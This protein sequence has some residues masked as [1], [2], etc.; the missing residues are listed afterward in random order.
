VVPNTDLGGASGELGGEARSRHD[1][2]QRRQITALFC[3]LVGS[4]PLSGRLDP[5]DFRE[6]LALYQ[7]VVADAIDRYNGQVTQLLGDGVVACFGYPRAHEDDAQRAVYAGLE[8]LNDLDDLNARLKSRFDATLQVR[9][10]CHTGLVVAGAMEAGSKRDEFAM[11]GETPNV[12]ARLQAVATPGSLVV[13]EVTHGLIQ[14]EFETELLGEQTLVGVERPIVV[15]RVLRS[16]AVEDRLDSVGE[17]RRSPLIDREVEMDMLLAIWRGVQQGR[18]TLVQ[19]TGEPGIGKSRLIHALAERLGDE[20]G[21]AQRWQC[22]RHHQSSALYPVIRLLESRYA[23]DHGEPRPSPLPKLLDAVAAV[24]LNPD[25]AVPLLVD[26]LPLGTDQSEHARLADAQEERTQLLR[27]LQTLLLGDP[28]QHPM[29]L[30]V[31]DLQW[32][33]PTTRELLWRVLNDLARLPVLCVVTY[34]P[35]FEWPWRRQPGLQIDLGPLDAR[36]VR[37]LAATI[38]DGGVDEDVVARVCATAGGVPLFIEEM[39]KMLT[40]EGPEQG[41]RP[42]GATVPV[43]LHGLLTERLDRL[44]DLGEVVDMAAVLGREFD[45][46]LLA[47]LDPLVSDL[48]TALATLTEQD[49]LRQVDGPA[50]SFEFRHALLQE[51]AYSRVLRRRRHEL[52]ARVAATLIERFAERAEREPELVAHHFSA[53]GMPDQAVGYWRAAGVRALEQAAFIEAAQHFRCGLE[54]L[55]QAGP[56]E[57]TNELRA[58]LLTHRAAALQ[59]GQGYA[60]PGVDDAYVRARNW[61]QT[62]GDERL[63]AVIRGQSMSHLVAADFDGTHELAE[64]MLKLAE[65]GQSGASLAEGHLY[66]GLAHMYRAE[67]PQA[68][69]HLEQAITAYR[70]PDHVDEVYEALGSTGAGAHAYLASVLSNMGHEREALAYSDRSL[71]LA[72]RV[73]RP[74]T[75]AQVWFMRA[76]LHLGRSE[77]KEFSE[78]VERARGFSVDRNIRYWRTLASAYSN[79]ARAMSADRLEGIAQLEA[80][81]NSY[82]QSGA[83]LGLAH[84]YVL[85]ANLQLAASAFSD[86][87]ATVGRGEEHIVSTGERLAEV[88]LLGCK[89]RVLIAGTVADESAAIASLQEAVDVAERQ[90]ARLPQL[91]A[92]RALVLRRRRAGEDASSDE[93]RLLALCD[94]F[95]RDSQLPD[96]LRARAMLAE[97]ARG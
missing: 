62:T 36:H 53:A 69:E 3:D 88:E 92:L 6:I 93:E 37:E 40:L 10:G 5:E 28:A 11:V 30:L 71:E 96:L 72:E 31:E 13:S 32:A 77:L 23:L 59:A 60:A 24:G 64:E 29:L 25:L 85:L 58:D 65:Q 97:A 22:S 68:R 87:M 43:T 42:A 80:S 21:L 61:W 19:L 20:L 27:T 41:A 44:S 54:A 12:A 75:R 50:V 66:A 82:R 18:G 91:R 49:I 26:L 34:R 17:E 33:D 7:E 52:H 15:Y 94:R 70:W 56:G 38:T 35:D 78:W 55:E 63:L 89:A 46:E 48:D 8:V 90:G 1:G 4:T 84:L 76:I 95:D 86:A 73:N 67:L 79:G 9:I 51:A 45:R 14:R 81:I 16:T 57:S 39:L 83:R 74:V 2:A 47:A